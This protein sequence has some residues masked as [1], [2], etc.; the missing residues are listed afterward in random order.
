[1]AN[2]RENNAQISNFKVSIRAYGYFAS[3]FYFETL[4]GTAKDYIGPLKFQKIIFAIINS[5]FALSKG[6]N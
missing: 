1:M 4:K 5:D 3:N 6:K 2:K